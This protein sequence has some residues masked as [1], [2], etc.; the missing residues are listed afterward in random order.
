MKRYETDFFGASR[1]EKLN[2]KMELQSYFTKIKKSEQLQQ[3][4]IKLSIILKEF[5]NGKFQITGQKF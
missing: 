5:R 1:T 3:L 4:T 2:M